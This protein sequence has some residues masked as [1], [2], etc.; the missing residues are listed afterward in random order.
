MTWS[1]EASLLKTRAVSGEDCISMTVVSI[2]GETECWETKDNSEPEGLL[3]KD[4]TSYTTIA[5]GHK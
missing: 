5:I 1:K 3:D 2:K 4:Y